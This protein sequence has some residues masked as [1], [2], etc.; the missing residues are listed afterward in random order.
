[1]EGAERRAGDQLGV[2]SAELVDRVLAD[3]Q[4]ALN[5]D[6]AAV[7][8]SVIAGGRGVDAVSALAGTGKTTMIGA[9]AACYAEAGWGVVGVAP[10]G[11]AA[12]ELRDIAGVPAGTMHSLL[13]S[14]QRGHGFAERT[15]LVLDE[16]GMAPTRLAAELFWRAERAGV[17]VSR[18]GT[19][20]S[21]DRF[22]PEAGSERSPAS[23]Q[24]WC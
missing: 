7:V 1:M 20:D 9:L 10:T 19:R 12:R 3:H 23:S 17:K 15:L 6:Q 14:L 4:P 24:R 13:G 5:P 21:F 11:R 8:R 16:A 22:R 18:S 2:L